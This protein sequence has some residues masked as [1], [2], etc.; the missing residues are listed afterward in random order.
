MEKYK[1]TVKQDLVQNYSPSMMRHAIKGDLDYFS[2][3]PHT[4]YGWKELI[5]E[6]ID[7][8]ANGHLFNGCG[9]KN[10]IHYWIKQYIYL[11]KLF[12]KTYD[13]MLCTSGGDWDKPYKLGL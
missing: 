12:N 13:D 9:E 4:Y 7:N 11:N 1:T 3:L 2:N 8:L 10:N 6:I 5:D